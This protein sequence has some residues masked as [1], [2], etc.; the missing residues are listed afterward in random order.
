VRWTAVVREPALVFSAPG[1]VVLRFGGGRAR[2]PRYDLQRLLPR[3]A[4]AARADAAAVLADARSLAAARLGDVRDNP[5]YDGAR[6][7]A[8]AM[9]PGAEIE[10]RVFRRVRRLR[11]PDSAE[12][13]SRLVLG[14]EDLAALDA[15]LADVRVAD[16]RALQW[17]FL[18]ERRAGH[19]LV[20]LGLDDSRSKDGTTRY[21]LAPPVAPLELD[22]LVLDSDAPFFDRAYRLLGVLAD[23]E[24]TIASGRLVRPIGDPRPV[25]VELPRARVSALVLLVEDG[26]DAP[27]AFRSIQARTETPELFLTAPPGD[28]EL[29]LGAPDSSAPRYELERVRDVVLAVRAAEIEAGALEDNPDF[30][31]TARL[32]GGGTRQTVL[33]WTVLIAAVAGLGAYTLRLAR[34]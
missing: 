10:R 29:L 16:S 13:L 33:L 8:F 20:P 30:S 15:D 27:L 22:R 23:D 19:A 3:V 1:D 31:V 7:L 32:R 4:T 24:R 34:R 25:S 2:A 26:D 18:I 6:V 5:D 9:R 17:P 11:V 12:G 28:Y 21:V 14:P